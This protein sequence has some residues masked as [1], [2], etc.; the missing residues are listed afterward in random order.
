MG[1]I[2]PSKAAFNRRILPLR[3]NAGSSESRGKRTFL[4]KSA[5]STM[6]SGGGG[7]GVGGAQGFPQYSEEYKLK[8]FRNSNRAFKTISNCYLQS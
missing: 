1:S 2:N 3:S 7:G 4:T 5:E 8:S 6:V